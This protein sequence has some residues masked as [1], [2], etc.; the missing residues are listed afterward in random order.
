M[1]WTLDTLSDSSGKCRPVGKINARKSRVDAI[2][3]EIA[4]TVHE[5]RTLFGTDRAEIIPNQRRWIYR[6]IKSIKEWLSNLN[7]FLTDSQTKEL[8]S[9]PLWK[10]RFDKFKR[11]Y[12]W[13]FHGIQTF[14]SAYNMRLRLA[15]LLTNILKKKN[16]ME[17]KFSLF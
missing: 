2:N 15:N 12:G 8:I 5:L 4:T 14:K 9:L 1:K 11:I 6:K 13:S 16:N 3:N 7:L 17:L 10:I